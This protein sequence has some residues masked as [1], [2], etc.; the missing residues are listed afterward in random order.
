MEHDLVPA[1]DAAGLP[2]PPWLF[3]VL[4]V[5]TFFLH[6]LFM[7]L[8]LGGTILAWV[9]H[10]RGGGRSD[11]PNGVLAG[12]MMAINSYAISLTI[13]TGVAPLL[14]IQVLYQQFFYSGTILLGWIWFGVLALLIAGYYAAYAYKFRG[15]PTRGAGG[16]LWLGI[17]AIAFL[18]IAMIHVA[19]HLIHIQPDR[20]LGFAD[21]PWLVLGDPTYWP[22]LLHFVLASIAFS[23]LVLTWWAARR[24]AA[25]ADVEINTA[26]ARSC[27]RWALW[28][29]ALQIVDGFVL[30]IVLPPDVLTGIMRGGLATLG[31]LTL[32]ILLGV[33]LLTMLAR[34]LDPVA[35]RGLV[36]GTLA[37]M[38]L[39]VAVMSITRHQVRVLYLEPVTSAYTK[40]IVP[41]WGN[42]FLFAVFLVVGLA[43]VGYMTK[44]V[45]SEPAS[46]DEAA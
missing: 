33:G 29:T 36:T 25:G 34:P 42:F 31:P 16:G 41:Q 28:T 44:R 6:A 14:F 7:N 46:G 30:L 27:W 13:T 24:A 45:L 23:A 8:T 1:V 18:L 10:V 4:L 22:R 40:Q 37:A 26:I 32:S 12:R 17:T 15:A 5:F 20:W 38:L 11:G 3:H 19:V 39:T 43:A 21:N 9:A 35:R 2:G